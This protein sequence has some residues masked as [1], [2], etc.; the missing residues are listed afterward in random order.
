[1]NALDEVKI[2]LSAAASQSLTSLYATFFPV[3]LRLAQRYSAN[4]Y[5]PAQNAPLGRSYLK[6]PRQ[7]FINGRRSWRMRSADGLGRA[8]SSLG[9]YTSLPCN[10]P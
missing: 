10:L 8:S 6:L 3:V 4:P 7:G 1:M 9:R 5:G 2:T